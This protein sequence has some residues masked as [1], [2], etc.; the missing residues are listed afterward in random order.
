VTLPTPARDEESSP[1]P[2]LVSIPD[3]T[4]AILPP[5]PE[6]GGEP[7][8]AAEPVIETPVDEPPDAG[9]SIEGPAEN[10]AP[11]S[12]APDAGPTGPEEDG[13]ALTSESGAGQDAGG[14]VPAEESPRSGPAPPSDEEEPAEDPAGT[15]PGGTFAV[16]EAPETTSTETPTEATG[17]RIEV[18]AIDEDVST[19]D[20]QSPGESIP[21][22]EVGEAPPTGNQEPAEDRES[23]PEGIT[24]ASQGEGRGLHAEEEQLPAGDR[25]GVPEQTTAGE[26]FRVPESPRSE[27]R[28][29]RRVAGDRSDRD[30]KVGAADRLARIRSADG[31][32]EAVQEKVSDLAGASG[33]REA[34]DEPEPAREPIVR[35]AEP[36][37]R[38][39]YLRSD[40]PASREASGETAL[41]EERQAPDG[42][43]VERRSVVVSRESP[44]RE[45]VRAQQTL[46]PPPEPSAAHRTTD[47]V[48]Q[49]GRR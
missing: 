6:A 3:E 5:D 40:V 22:P 42:G 19:A 36:A 32:G 9:T 10:P 49:G 44:E 12:E 18:V 31:G 41:R 2:R 47:K 17:Q 48:R 24:E 34:A 46:E 43:A 37:P 1:S 28:I 38:A 30:R 13:F 39:P 23:T 15:S 29:E 7:P 33:G 11:D 8:G 14:S 26:G 20:A 25:V 35:S 45:A 27:E 4:A 16:D 21:E